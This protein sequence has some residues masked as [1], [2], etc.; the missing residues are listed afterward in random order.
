MISTSRSILTNNSRLLVKSYP[1][2]LRATYSASSSSKSDELSYTE[3]QTK[4]GRPV[5]PHVTV[6]KFPVAAL[7]SIANRVTGVGLS[8]GK[9]Y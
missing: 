1:L 7:S 4:L 6:Y 9:V 5:S 2:V 3:R 8:A